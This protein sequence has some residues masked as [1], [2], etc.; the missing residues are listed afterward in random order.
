MHASPCAHPTANTTLLL[1]VLIQ[2]LLSRNSYKR[3]VLNSSQVLN[4]H[5]SMYCAYCPCAHP[6]PVQ[7]TVGSWSELFTSPLPGCL[8]VQQQVLSTLLH[9]QLQSQVKWVKLSQN[10]AKN[11]LQCMRGFFLQPTSKYACEALM[12]AGIEGPPLLWRPLMWSHS[13]ARKPVCCP[14]AK[15]GG[16]TCLWTKTDVADVD[17]L[18]YL[19]KGTPRNPSGFLEAAGSWV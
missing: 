2:L 11:S 17:L 10:A 3:R 12:R 15:S 14:I 6:T 7:A 19:I 13:A 5:C 18:H 9:W 1:S 16:T 4:S 8:R